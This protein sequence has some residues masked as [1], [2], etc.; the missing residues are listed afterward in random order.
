MR[1]PEESNVALETRLSA[2]EAKLDRMETLLRMV[3]NS[4]TLPQTVSIA[5]I[6][7]ILGVSVSNLRT[8]QCYLLPNWGKS[9][10][11]DGKFRWKYDTFL[12]HINSGTPEELKERYTREMVYETRKKRASRLA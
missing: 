2:L 1:I 10:F 4:I 8:T 7:R 9:E 3:V 12:A 11:P 5:D 6:S